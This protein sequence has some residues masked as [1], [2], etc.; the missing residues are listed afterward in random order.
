MLSPEKAIVFF[1]LD[2]S[3]M[4]L[5]VCLRNEAEGASTT[6]SKNKNIYSAPG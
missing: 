2:G 6:V 5:V 1:T 4:H 3:W